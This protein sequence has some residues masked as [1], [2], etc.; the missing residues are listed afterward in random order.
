V[1]GRLS[2]PDA[3]GLATLAACAAAGALGLLPGVAGGLDPVTA[4]GWMAL[5]APAAGALCGARGLALF[6]FSLS[7]PALW[8]LELTLVAARVERGFPT[9]LWAACALGGL[10]AF[11]H[12]L[13]GRS[14][15]PLR[16]PLV[17]A[18]ALLSLG[19]FLAGAP[20]GFG[21]VAGGTELARLH[22]WLAARLLDASPL[23]LVFDCAGWDWTHAQPEVYAGAGVEWFQRRAYPG[24]LAGPAVLVVG[25]VLASLARRSHARGLPDPR[26]R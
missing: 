7:V 24:N 8:V 25:C 21:L 5:C 3:A 4:L 11:G 20:Q 18:G 10:F 22:P 14:P 9:P 26:V 16:S 17:A 15:A 2:P 23:V 19:L 12:A 13:G 6:P 1:F